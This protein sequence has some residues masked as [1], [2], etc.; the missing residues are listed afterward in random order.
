M[1]L[2]RFGLIVKYYYD[3]SIKV[4]RYLWAVADVQ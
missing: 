4:S 2:V 3:K 1:K